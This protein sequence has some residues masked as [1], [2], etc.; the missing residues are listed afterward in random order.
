MLGWGSPGRPV[1]R[2]LPEH[3]AAVAASRLRAELERREP[4]LIPELH[5]RAAAWCQANGLEE[6]AIDHAQAAGDADQVARLVLQAM[7]PVW[8]SGR[9]TP[10]WDGCSGWSASS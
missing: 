10:C 2:R 5:R 7:Q 8:A 1:H 4:E 3:G 6:T 9:S